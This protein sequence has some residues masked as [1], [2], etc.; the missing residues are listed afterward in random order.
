MDNLQN[1]SEQPL[2]R[3]SLW[4]TAPIDC[5]PDSPP[6][7][8]AVVAFEP[9]REE[10][11]ETLLLKLQ[12]LEREFGRKPK[13]ILNEPR[14]LDLDLIAFATRCDEQD[15]VL[16][17]PRA[18]NVRSCCIPRIAPGC[19]SGQPARVELLMNC[20]RSE[21]KSG[22]AVSTVGRDRD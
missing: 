22:S 17:H 5:P 13:Q 20:P 11:P 14:P 4:R 7:I 18:F 21:R 10:T 3:S 16:P 6:F 9:G 1:L 2:L 15:L 12:N 8:N 19:I